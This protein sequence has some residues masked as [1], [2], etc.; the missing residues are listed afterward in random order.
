[1]ERESA[2]AAAVSKFACHYETIENL[3]NA[4]VVRMPVNKRLAFLVEGLRS[5]G[6]LRWMRRAGAIS[7][8]SVRVP[9]RSHPARLWLAAFVA[10]GYHRDMETG[11]ADHVGCRRVVTPAMEN[12]G[13][14]IDD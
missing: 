5:C 1:M 7:G 4:D 8:R 13:N 6:D 14:R 2:E 10:D 3:E 11:L 9:E 12:M